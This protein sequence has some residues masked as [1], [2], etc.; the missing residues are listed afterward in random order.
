MIGS[1]DDVV[2][3]LVSAAN[4]S[5]PES[6]IALETGGRWQLDTPAR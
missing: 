5:V 2:T 4:A 3:E 6:F 1:P